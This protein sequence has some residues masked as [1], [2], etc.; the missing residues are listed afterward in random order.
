MQ[1]VVDQAQLRSINSMTARSFTIPEPLALA[2]FRSVKLCPSIRSI[3]EATLECAPLYPVA[4]SARCAA[5]MSAHLLR[6]YCAMIRI[7][8]G[9]TVM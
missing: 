9:L 5:L 4:P 8:G 2:S 1:A 7:H 3:D 6:S